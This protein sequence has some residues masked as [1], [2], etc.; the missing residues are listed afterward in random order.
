MRIAKIIIFVILFST[1]QIY[2][3]AS[4]DS[5][6]DL[7]KEY[8]SL[9]NTDPDVK[10]KEE[11]VQLKKRLYS[12]GLR[13]GNDDNVQALID[14]AFLAQKIDG[15][16]E[17]VSIL[18]LIAR[19][20][21]NSN[22]ADDALM[23]LGDLYG[24]EMKQPDKAI[25]Y[26]KNII[27]KY[28]DSDM[29][30]VAGMRLEVAN[31]TDSKPRIDV[32]R[33]RSKP[34]V[35]IDPGHG[36][37]DN[38]A[39]APSGLYEK[40]VVLDVA[41]E[42]EQLLKEDGDIEVEL[43]RRTDVFV[44]LAERT[45]LSNEL[46]ADAFVSL[47][48]NSSPK[49]NASGIETYYLDNTNDKGALRLAEVENAALQT[50]EEGD[51]S[52]ILSDLIQ[53]GKLG[54]SIKLSNSIH[55]SIVMFMKGTSEPLNDLGVKKGPFYVLVG[56]HTPCA[57]VEIG[58]I[59]NAEDGLNLADSGFRKNIAQGAFLGIKNYFNEKLH[60]KNEPIKQLLN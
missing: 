3:A 22:L 33:D 54:D 12:V 40:D 17:A 8:F 31:K 4:E 47:H 51:L 52:M 19:S 25:E 45:G 26:Y 48:A 11:W 16:G 37:D 34:L 28:P 10:K 30:V 21:P 57:L 9:R 43:T 49:R 20:Y 42:V 36:G 5:L 15:V 46:D 58:F 44:P 7:R 41:I 27:E 2:E 59:D 60:S 50:T 29:A 35:I 32:K 18:E 55:N 56:T 38:G 13:S 6:Q 23:R 53:R 39:Q 14:A 1:F 24:E